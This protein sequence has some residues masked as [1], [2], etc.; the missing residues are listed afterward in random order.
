[1]YTILQYIL[2][3][4]GMVKDEDEDEDDNSNEDN[5]DDTRARMTMTN[6][7]PPHKKNYLC[8][9]PYTL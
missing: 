7:P 4:E 8:Y 9:Y 1:M 2:F 5:N 6:D 3:Q